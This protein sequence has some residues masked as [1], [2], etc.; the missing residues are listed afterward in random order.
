MRVS[1]GAFSEC[2]EPIVGDEGVC[3]PIGG[4]TI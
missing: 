4:T 1:E 3:S 2:Y